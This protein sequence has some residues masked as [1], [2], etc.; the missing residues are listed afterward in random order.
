MIIKKSVLGM[1]PIT[2]L[3]SG[4]ALAQDQTAPASVPTDA[5]SSQ[6]DRVVITTTK[7]AT[8]LQDTPQAVSAFSQKDLDKANVQDLTSLQTMV[9]NLSVEQHGDSGGGVSY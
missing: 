2:L 5:G 8:L 7:R 3:S 1:L 9:P 6:L 4:M